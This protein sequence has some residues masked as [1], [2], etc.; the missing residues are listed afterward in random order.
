MPTTIDD[1][2]TLCSI[3]QTVENSRSSSAGA[4]AYS[5]FSC[6]FSNLCGLFDTSICHTGKN[7][8]ERDQAIEMV[9]LLFISLSSRTLWGRTWKDEHGQSYDNNWLL[10]GRGQY[11]PIKVHLDHFKHLLLWSLI[12]VNFACVL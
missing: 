2:V 7:H 8:R 4:V 5:K 3:N 10:H 6:S 12:K 1:D 11:L 9:N